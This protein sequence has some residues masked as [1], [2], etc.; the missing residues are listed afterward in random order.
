MNLIDTMSDYLVTFSMAG[1]IKD[2]SAGLA[3]DGLE[4][5]IC[6]VSNSSDLSK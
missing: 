1:V 4:I 2:G 3:S 6:N 5:K